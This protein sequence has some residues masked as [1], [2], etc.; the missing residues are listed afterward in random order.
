ML[1][2]DSKILTL[3]RIFKVFRNP[4]QR[5]QQSTSH[6]TQLYLIALDKL[7]IL[8][9]KWKMSEFCVD[10][11][12]SF[13]LREQMLSTLGQKIWEV[14]TGILLARFSHRRSQVCLASVSNGSTSFSLLMML[15]N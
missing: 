10:K 15:L 8:D 14:S 11:S 7:N 4:L 3:K 13:F 5:Q 6:H 2:I 1:L 12:E 9:Y